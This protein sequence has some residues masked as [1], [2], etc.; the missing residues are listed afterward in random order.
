MHPIGSAPLS[1]SRVSAFKNC[2]LA[3]RYRYVDALPERPSAAALRGNLVHSALE[4]LFRQPAE[5]RSMAVALAHLDPGLDALL[6]E[7]PERVVAVDESLPWPYDGSS[8][9]A[10]Q[11]ISAFKAEAA[12]LIERYFAIEDP[13]GVDVVELERYTRA[14]LVDGPVVHGYID[15]LERAAVSGLVVSDYKTGKVPDPRFREKAWSQLLTYALLLRI[16]G[17]QVVE[18]RLHY[19]GGAAPETI[20]LRPSSDALDSLEHELRHTARVIQSRA[21]SGEFRAKQSP[22][23]N[24][25]DFQRHCPAKGGRELPWPPA[26]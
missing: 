18:L 9:P 3:F 20:K 19:L 15:R 21:A 10:P 6:E 17:E 8:E 7:S 11:T 22:L 24:F 26:A 23:C 14:E 16:A 5:D 13:K 4:H 2:E 25:C 1:P 12:R